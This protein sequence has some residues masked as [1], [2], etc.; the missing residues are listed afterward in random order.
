MLRGFFIFG[1]KKMTR[2]KYDW[3]KIEAEYRTGRFSNRQLETMYG[4]SEATIRN[5]AKKFGWKKDLTDAVRTRTK[6]MTTAG[7]ADGI[8]SSGA[9]RP[10]DEQIIEA[11]AATGASIV[12]QHRSYAKRGREVIGKLLDRLEGQ[13]AR[14]KITISSFGKESEIDI[15][16]DYV[17]KVVNSATQSLERI[18][19]IERQAFNLDADADSKENPSEKLTDD[20]LDAEIERRIAAASSSES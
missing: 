17:G 3:E 14:E 1:L 11:A 18:V 19:K 4:P 13:L 6:E 2:Q 15:P 16:L 20:E 12:F 5:R 7:Q 9:E 8:D 10:T